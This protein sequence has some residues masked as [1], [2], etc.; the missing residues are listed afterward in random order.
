MKKTISLFAFSVLVVVAIL[1]TYSSAYIIT[2]GRQAIV[3][4]FG[5]PVGEPVTEAGLHFKIPFI[6]KI[7]YVD[8]RILS[9]DGYPNQIPTRDKKYIVVDTTARWRID[10]ALKFI[11]TVMK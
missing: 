10:D 8:K 5:R 7:Q 11:Q 2:E 1:G 4:Q 6:Q 9:W 3:T